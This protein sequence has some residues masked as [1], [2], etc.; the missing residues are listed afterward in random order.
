MPH[1]RL[2]SPS[3]TISVLKRHDL[4]TRKSLG[5]H[6]LIDDNV[7]GRIVDLADLAPGE[8]VLE[9]GPGIGTLTDALLGTG[10]PVVA[11]EFDTRLLPALEELSRAVMDA[12]RNVMGVDYYAQEIEDSEEAIIRER[13]RHKYSSGNWTACGTE[14][15]V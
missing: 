3:A 8:P 12:F 14:N 9:V 11:I 15:E 7:V 6:F 2:A 5:Q 4:Y 10:A 13:A 1:S